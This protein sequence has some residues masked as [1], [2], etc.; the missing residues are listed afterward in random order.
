MSGDIE[1]LK[2]RLGELADALEE[3]ETAIKVARARINR[4]IGEL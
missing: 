2:K 3:L 1:K 4:I